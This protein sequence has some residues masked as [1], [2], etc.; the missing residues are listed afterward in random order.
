VY[1]GA[2]GEGEKGL[3]GSNGYDFK[4]LDTME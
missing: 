1:E 4:G 2:I 3:F